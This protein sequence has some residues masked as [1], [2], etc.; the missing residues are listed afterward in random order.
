MADIVVTVDDRERALLSRLSESLPSGR[1][2]RQ[3]LILGDVLVCH[4]SG[5]VA[6]AIERK[7][8]A[9]LTA[10][11]HDGRFADQRARLLEIDAG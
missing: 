4:T 8:V 11:L 1:I 9:D 6:F 3:R 7:T 10:S 2:T 5:E